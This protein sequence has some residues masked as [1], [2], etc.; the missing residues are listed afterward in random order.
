MKRSLLAI[1]IV[2][3]ISMAGIA[4]A[5]TSGKAAA[6]VH[7]DKA[8]A[9]AYEPG[10]DMIDVFDSLCGP[11]ISERGP[12]IPGLQ[13]APPVA[14]RKIPDREYWASDAAK[15]FDNLYW[16]GTQDD[17]T[18]AVI[19][20]QG[21][22]LVDSGYDYSIK[23]RVESLKKLGADPAQIKYVV[24][25]HAHGDRY[26]G[27]KYVQDTYK[28]RVVMS[29][30][31]WGVLAKSNEP[32]EIKPKKDMIATDGMKLTL[33]DTTIMLY[34]TP[35]HT[36]GTISTI[37]PL[38]DGNQKHVGVV[39]GGMA[40]SYERYGVRYYSSLQETF[41]TWSDSIKRFTAIEEKAGADVYLAIHAH[42]DRTIEK[43]RALKYR[44]PGAPHPFVSASA[45]KRFLTIMGECTDAQL[46]RVTS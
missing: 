24:L 10:Q 46:A 31:D 28:A 1:C 18:W 12:Q 30:A 23:E 43:L 27:A 36:P 45:V 9:L 29:E 16:I 26:F 40:P 39:W 13:V 14:E 17:S 2:A 8:K 38:R 32:N 3:L 5:Q 4:N 37:I 22:I 25:S 35:G 7:I 42:Y 11:A 34:L 41:K 19:T 21:I 44:K 20:T 33:G 6:Q 15:V